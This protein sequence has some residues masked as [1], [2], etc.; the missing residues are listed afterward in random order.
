MLHYSHARF[1]VQVEQS[2][3]Y[4]FIANSAV[5]YSLLTA[6]VISRVS[7]IR[8]RAGGRGQGGCGSG[9]TSRRWA[10]P[11]I[12]P[13]TV[14]LHSQQTTGM[15]TNHRIDQKDHWQ[16]S[17]TQPILISAPQWPNRTCN[18][19]TRLYRV[20]KKPSVKAYLAIYSYAADASGQC[21]RESL[22]LGHNLDFSSCDILV[23]FCKSSHILVW[24]TLHY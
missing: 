7:L 23:G 6:T 13:Q 17:G 12:R 8:G 24:I 16:Q 3:S 15:Y 5:Q 22:I 4:C 1:A 19:P 10:L 9:W 11:A 20:G 2:Y 18:A 14:V 21:M